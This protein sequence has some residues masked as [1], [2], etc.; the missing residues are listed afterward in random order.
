MMKKKYNA[1]EAEIELF[2]VVSVFTISPTDP[3]Y[4]GSGGEGDNNF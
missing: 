2:T 4:D 3:D 1:P